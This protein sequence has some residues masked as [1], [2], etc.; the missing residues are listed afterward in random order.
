MS[1]RDTEG[2]ELLKR[3]HAAFRIGE[4]ALAEKLVAALEPVTP[5]SPDL[6]LLSGSIKGRQGKYEEA[7]AS[8][9]SVLSARPGNAEALNN[10]GVMYRKLGRPEDAV[11]M[12]QTA[13]SR[14]P[15]RAD[16]HYNLGNA[17]K[18]LG[19]ADKAAAAYRR[20][21]ELDPAFAG[22][23]NNLGTLYETRN[24][25]D[26]AEKTFTRGLEADASNPVLKYNLG[27][28]LASENRLE[29]AHDAFRDA[30]RSRPGWI[31]GLN[32]L[33]IVLNKLGR[34]GEAIETFDRILRLQ[35]KNP[36]AKNN[37][38]A[39]Y[40]ALGKEELAEKYLHSAL[41]DDPAYVRAALNL[42]NLLHDSGSSEE[43]YRKVSS[44]VRLEPD[45]NELRYLLARVC[46]A[47]GRFDESETHLSW[48]LNQ[49][50]DSPRV[51]RQLGA[52]SFRRGDR[53]RGERYYRKAIEH[54]HPAHET[55]IELA[56][57]F[58]SAGELDAAERELTELA[59]LAPDDTDAQLLLGELYL[60]RKKGRA[61]ANL[62]S[63]FL[64][65]HPGDKTALRGL[66][67]AYHQIG[68]SQNAVRIAE[69][70]V[71][72]HGIG[73]SAE[74]LSGLSDSLDV[75]EEVVKPFEES[76]DSSWEER[77]R[78]LDERDGS[79]PDERDTGLE[80]ESDSLM[81]SDL[82]N[83]DEYAPTLL[84]PEQNTDPVPEHEL[85]T[86]AGIDSDN[87]PNDTDGAE[88]PSSTGA[89]EETDNTETPEPGSPLAPERADPAR[90]A[91]SDRYTA[92]GPRA[93]RD[94][95]R[96]S[97]LTDR[98]DPEDL[99]ALFERAGLEIEAERRTGTDTAREP[100]DTDMSDRN[101][102]KARSGRREPA[103]LRR[104]P[105]A[106]P[107]DQN[108][109]PDTFAGS[110]NP[111]PTRRPQPDDS[112]HQA[113]SYPRMRPEPEPGVQARTQVPGLPAG[114]SEP[115][116]DPQSPG[117]FTRHGQSQPLPRA[118][119]PE[120]LPRRESADS[121]R[122]NRPASVSAEPTGEP[123]TLADRE[124]KLFAYLLEMTR[125]L[126]PERRESFSQSDLRLRLERLRAVLEGRTGLKRRLERRAGF[127]LSKPRAELNPAALERTFSYLERLIAYHPD[128]QIGLALKSKLSHIVERIHTYP[129]TKDPE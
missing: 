69:E 125:H 75:Y 50:P 2:V 91:D 34:N 17:Y 114:P 43:A 118:L 52:L 106:C 20:A 80:D 12:L 62:F 92:P 88:T 19:D 77:L 10:I 13:S 97:R 122:Q 85:E 42:G 67:H 95:A 27:V 120:A 90:Y 38:A 107:D 56:G 15:K 78:E 40:T 21:I 25:F 79:E 117:T 109:R 14:A 81:L 64:S 35:P 28:T 48:L 33:G 93:D 68:D 55:R 108:D 89:S 51:L 29:E 83:L 30:L 58:R 60:E 103:G 86:A 72:R 76:F 129:E 53:E 82:A 16:I 123:D 128:T 5:E 46:L 96:L 101:A 31:E 36:I 9:R 44:M 70:L 87:D 74:D 24:A 57:A 11:R 121:V 100:F 63:A 66:A 37:L 8:F 47:L 84:D 127:L 104:L 23:Y 49:E 110:W 7:I 18:Q 113:G 73:T 116:P 59:A 26:E 94:E 3:A 65:R 22:A 71:N 99:S 61:A 112:F 54:E 98:P 126:P 105:A 124:A 39:V 1:A 6:M 111:A 102:D 45:N 119:P 32:N 115:C 4:L 41:E